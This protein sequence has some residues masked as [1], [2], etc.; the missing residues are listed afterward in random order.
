LKDPRNIVDQGGYQAIADLLLAMS[1]DAESVSFSVLAPRVYQAD[2][3]AVKLC[4]RPRF[5]QRRLPGVNMQ[6]RWSPPAR[7]PT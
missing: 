3:V 2:S 4:C 1:I 5:R 6:A 7:W